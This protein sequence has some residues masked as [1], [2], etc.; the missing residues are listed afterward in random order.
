MNKRIIKKFSLC[1]PETLPYFL[2][3][4][5]SRLQLS[6][7]I[8]NNIDFAKGGFFTLLPSTTNEKKLLKFSEGD[9]T[10]SV[11]YGLPELNH[12]GVLFQPEEILT[13]NF[14]S[15]FFI[16][17]FLKEIAS[18][19]LII[20]DYNSQST[21]P[22]AAINNIKMIPY[23]KQV[24]HFLNKNNNVEEINKVLRICNPLWYSLAVIS[25][26]DFSLPSVL[27]DNHIDQICE[28]VKYIFTTAYDGEGYL[29]WKSNSVDY[30]FN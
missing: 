25:V 26:I 29:F 16:L 12:Y 30:A 20:E 2:D 9:I 8:L 5:K 10:P 24:Y 14:E 1:F 7:K 27:E 11:P 4:I 15:C 18:S 19:F 23:E 3:H 22:N 28:N 13:A 6:N 21:D 17:S